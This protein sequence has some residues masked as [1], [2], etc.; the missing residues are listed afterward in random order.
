MERTSMERREALRL[1]AT[2]AIL[3]L[4]VPRNL[5]ALLRQ[6]RAVL[7]ENASPRTLNPRQYATVK[8]M[9]E[10]ILPK[11][12]TPGAADVGASEFIDLMLTEWYD[13]QERAVFLTG[14][15]DLD[16]RTNALFGKSF[17]DCPPDQQ[18]EILSSLGERMTEE[19]NA[20]PP[21]LR[22]HRRSEPRTPRS[23]YAMLRRLTLTAYYT[24]EAGATEAL[25]FEIIPDHFDACAVLGSETGGPQK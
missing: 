21:D 10:L 14:L 3:P 24:S 4:A 7:G 9:A 1:L 22:Q 23:F 6:A 5:F 8:T 19:A 2:G 12:E 20:A 17:V 16:A 18:A 13:D 11:T 15:A 25:H